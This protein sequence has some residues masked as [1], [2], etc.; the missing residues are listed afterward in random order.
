MTTINID[1]RSLI[2]TNYK[3]VKGGQE[4]HMP[5]FLCGGTDRFILWADTG[6]WWCR[7]CN[8][9]GS[10]IDLL[11]KRDNLSYP[12][13]CE[14]VGKPLENRPR[15]IPTPPPP[16]RGAGV[17]IPRQ[18]E[19]DILAWRQCALDLT[20]RAMSY[21]YDVGKDGNDYP[22][23][24]GKMARDYLH[25]RGLGRAPL[26]YRVGYVPMD[27]RANWGGLDVFIPKGLLIPW[28]DSDDRFSTPYKINIRRLDGQ[29][30]KY[31]MIKGSQNG[32]FGGYL[33]TRK[34]VVV[35]VEGEFDAMAVTNGTFNRILGVATGST[36]GGR[37]HKDIAQLAQAG[38]V[39]VAYDD[40]EA[41]QKASEYWLS[42]LPNSTR[43]T[44]LAK[45]CG[46]MAKER[47]NF[48]QWILKAVD[49]AR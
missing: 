44:P 20:N 24:E 40:D 9:K 23:Q 18:N 27:Y 48:V 31:L 17:S 35:L 29:E 7:Q 39:F 33:I 46:D 5:C 8:E 19:H 10:A 43:L 32:L 12:E 25:M 34:S 16:Q 26:F 2:V 30:P 45:D 14:R 22:T 36:M 13:A 49:N 47:Q 4:Y 28:F 37:R 21:L 38:H 6:R 1:V 42:V 11:M 15:R 3:A 41:G